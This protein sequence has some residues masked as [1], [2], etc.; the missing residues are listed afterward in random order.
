MIVVN[1]KIKVII[2]TLLIVLEVASTYLMYRSFNNKNVVLDNVKLKGATTKKSGLAIMIEQEDGTYKESTSSTWPEDMMYNDE[3]SGCIDD[4]GNAIDGALTYEGG[5]ANIRTKSSS[6]C[7]L[8]FDLIKD[9]VTISLSTDGESGVMPSSGAYTNS[10]TCSSGNITWSDKY[11]RI[12]IGNLTKPTKCNLTF[13]KDTSSKILLKTEVENKATTNANGYRY[14]GKAPNNWVW[15]NNEKWRII[16]SIP[17]CTSSGCATKENL[18]K[19]I[20]SESIGAYVYD[21]SSIT[22]SSVIGAWGSNTLYG[23]LN[24]YYYANDATAMNGQNHAGCYTVYT[25]YKPRPNC[26]YTEIGILS[27]SYYGRMVKQVYW[28]TGASNSNVTA[29]TAYTNETAK[30]TVLGHVGLMSASDWGYAASS[31]YHSITMG[32]YTSSSNN[33]TSTSWIFNNGYEWTSIQGSGYTYI[34]L[35]VSS[36]GYLYN[37]FD[38]PSGYSVRPVV[39]LDSSVY[40]VS[41]EGTEAN[42]YQIGM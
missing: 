23:L 10:A 15:F 32:T 19:I 25:S 21:A 42:P 5:V 34:P 20:R 37:Y 9:D 33:A 1:K 26:D 6:Y 16:G 22:L 3:K 13:T 2:I 35:F 17:T 29:G 12:E 41:G 18:V 40:I 27:S 24:T 14:S 11:Q 8:Y 4:K 7:F 39:Y 28:N 31:S 36:Y 30:Q 38:S